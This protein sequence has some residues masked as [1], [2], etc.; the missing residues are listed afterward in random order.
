MPSKSVPFFR[1]WNRPTDHEVELTDPDA[2]L[3]AADRIA[4]A[5]DHRGAITIL[6]EANRLSRDRRLD[7][8]LVD[9]RS[10]AFEH[11]EFSREQ[12]TLPETEDLFPGVLIP[13]ITPDELS[14]TTLRSAITHHGSLI[15]RGLV[16]VDRVVQLRDDIDNAIACFDNQAEDGP[17]EDRPDL[18]GYFHSFARDQES[19]RQRIRNGGSIL[20]INSPATLFD[21]TE[22]FHETGMDQLAQ[23]YFGEPP[24][25]L[26]RKMTLHRIR[27]KGNTGGWHQDGAFMGEGIRSLNL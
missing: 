12:P 8:R 1:R 23:D 6:T 15:V 11:T 18:D 21:L 22:T 25:L 7:R 17:H 20:T 26:G 2:A 4:D 9:A 5:G 13:E 10:A 19:N 14:V 24:L 16:D 3:A 27:K